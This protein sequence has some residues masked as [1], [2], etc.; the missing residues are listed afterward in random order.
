LNRLK[1]HNE[2]IKK[3]WLRNFL[4][5]NKPE[6][7]KNQIIQLKKLLA[8]IKTDDPRFR[9]FIKDQVSS[10][11]KKER[12]RQTNLEMI[13]RLKIQNR[14]LLE[15]VGKLSDREAIMKSNMKELKERMT[16]VL[17]L[18][19]TLA[20]A[21][22]SCPICWGNDP[23]CTNCLGKGSAGWQSPNRKFFN[24]YVIPVVNYNK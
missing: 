19:I 2:K 24:Q 13:R 4:M 12:Q 5:K 22:G 1:I 7:Q 6:N 11:A 16:N 3:D 15:R 21:L 10:W 23:S 8:Q 20:S 17:K 14:K 18:N 9:L